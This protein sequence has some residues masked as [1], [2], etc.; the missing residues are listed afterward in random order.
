[1]NRTEQAMAQV[2]GAK[3]VTMVQS[4]DGFVYRT[5][6][7]PHLINSNDSCHQGEVSAKYH[8]L[9]ELFGEPHEYFDDYKSD[10]E[11][12]VEFDDGVVA[13]I[14]NWK[15]GRNYNGF[16]APHV[17]NINEWNIG[18]FSLEA[19]RR[20]QQLC[21]PKPLDQNIHVTVSLRLKNGADAKRVLSDMHYEFNDADIED[22]RIIDHEVVDVLRL[23]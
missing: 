10:A 18:G 8:Q 12:Y 13:T 15:N 11:W 1:M 22:F 7:K 9:V 17:E 2:T 21:K 23:R 3:K 14:Y 20:I 4:R 19:A 6:T 5:E 16:D